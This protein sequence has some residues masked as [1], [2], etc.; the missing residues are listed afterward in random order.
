M[1]EDSE[2]DYSLL[3]RLLGTAGYAVSAERVEDEAGMREALGRT[4]WDAVISDHNLPAFSSTGA[5]ETLK[6]CGIDI[7]FLIV[8]GQIGEDVAVE[9]ML[10]GAD[11]FVLKS[12]L[13]RLA[14][15]LARSLAA[16]R[17]RQREREAEATLR[18]REARLR[19]ITENL[20]GV[21]FQMRRSADDGELMLEYASEGT[22]KLFGIAAGE[23]L[24]DGTGA[25]DQ[26]FGPG[27][28]S[29]EAAF[30]ASLALAGD[31]RWEGRMHGAGGAD[32][33]VALA[34]SAR[35]AA[36]GD[37][38]WD[39]VIIDITAQKRAEAGIRE[40][41]THLEKAKEEERKS[42]AREIH[43]DI[44]GILTGIKFELAWLR[45][46]AVGGE[47]GL[48]IGQALELTAGARAAADRIMQNL[49]PA[50]LDLG[51]VAALE[52]LA[53]D[54]GNRY[55]IP[56]S[57]HSNRDPVA[58]P[59]DL[60]M[61]MFRICQESLTNVTKHAGAATVRVELFAGEDEVTLEIADD[62]AG[63]QEEALAKTGSFGVRGMRERA[64]GLGGWLEV[65]SRPDK[66]TTVM[67]CLPLGKESCA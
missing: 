11:D 38:L 50:I 4:G 39:G 59:E 34:G 44:G 45:S 36:G 49:R 57:F 47:I 43:D 14:P 31:V 48:H 25:L 23:L 64:A 6:S 65:D 20:P 32:R 66:G 52:W 16:A 37:L 33:W 3:V 22:R 42:I 9:A 27:R 40:L 18:E 41:S 1:V 58:L 8:S 29:L 15:A 60:R 67:L 13:A 56:C 53:R 21:V 54:F 30:N 63:M 17:T 46:H 19:S 28:E 35:P 62:G 7:P 51:I 55:E 12:R 26:L 2:L 61:A 10:A 5:L 24:G